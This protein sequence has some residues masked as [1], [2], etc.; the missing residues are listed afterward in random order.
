[1]QS[2][3]ER[4]LWLMRKCLTRSIFEDGSV[5]PFDTSGEVRGQFDPYKRERGKD[6]PVSAETMVGD[7]RLFNV[8]QMLED[9]FIRAIP[10]DFVECGIWRGG[11]CIYAT[12][13]FQTYEMRG[14]MVI[15]FDSFEGLPKG[16]HYKQDE[17]DLHHTMNDVFAVG[18]D[19]V[20]ANFHKY[21]VSTE[22][23]LLWKGWFRD[24]TKDYSEGADRERE[25]AVLRV[26]GDMY[27]GTM[28]PLLN[29]YG[30]VSPG[31]TVIIDDYG[32][33]RACREAVTDFLDHFYHDR[34]KPE[35]IEVDHTAVYW[36]VPKE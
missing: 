27:E 35:I 31:G 11:V 15:G 19:E 16:G 33:V 30:M 22:D 5:K 24:T 14:R 7:R 12:E 3:R 13:F 2:L 4:H 28:D 29:L 8:H 25:I 26:D 6:W 32:D 9:T 18:I 10:G 34:P 17:G 21:E 23:L 20:I 1:M 36:K